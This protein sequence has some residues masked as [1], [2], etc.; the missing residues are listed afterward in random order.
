VSAVKRTRSGVDALEH[1]LK[2][3]HTSDN[4]ARVISVDRNP[5]VLGMRSVVQVNVMDDSPE[6]QE[7]IVTLGPEPR[8]KRSP[9]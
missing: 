3:V 9:R 6:E 8:S 4:D 7:V 5:G 1:A 2:G